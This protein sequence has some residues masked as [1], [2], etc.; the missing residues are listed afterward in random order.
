MRFYIVILFAILITFLLAT[1]AEAQEGDDVISVDSSV[2]HLNIGVVNQ[3]GQPIKNLSKNDFVLYEDGVKQQITRFEKTVA[4]FSVVMILDMSGST[5]GFR[6]IIRSSASRFIDALGPEDRISIIE[7][8]DKVNILN[9][10]TNKRKTLFNSINSA[11]GRGKTKLYKALDVS[12]SKLAKEQNRR[13][14]II[15]LTDGVDTDIKNEDRKLLSKLE[16]NDMP[17]SID[18]QSNSKLNLILNKADFLGVTIY[19]LALPTGDPL[20]LADPQPIK[21][22]C[23]L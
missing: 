20:K 6:Q 22:R 3:S 17:N 9:D 5:L 13:K 21:L 2:V 1:F 4:P 8:Y 7:F 10:F 19:P 16:E 11:N 15:V 23:S 18:P 14:A 12:L